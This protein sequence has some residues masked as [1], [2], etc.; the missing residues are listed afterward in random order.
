M[1]DLYVWSVLIPPFLV[2]NLFLYD[3]FCGQSPAG[4]IYN[5]SIKGMGIAQDH[6]E[7]ELD[8]IRNMLYG[9]L[10]ASQEKEIR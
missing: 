7:E 2:S 3:G 8:E 1:P 10:A 5:V 9:W 4:L 6:K